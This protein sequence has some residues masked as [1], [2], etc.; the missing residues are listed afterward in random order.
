VDL[1]VPSTLTVERD[2]AAE[3]KMVADPDL[4]TRAF[5]NLVKN[6]CEAMESGG[7][8]LLATRDVDDKVE[9]TVVDTGP[10]IP[11]ADREKV[12]TPYFTTREGGTGLGLAIVQR[13]IEDHGG[14][15]ALESPLPGKHGARFVARIPRQP[16]VEATRG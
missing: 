2:F 16:P 5:G 13:A 10:G 14:T 8:L 11:E 6:A 12:F 9:V 1:Y 4:L 3:G 7:T 15:L